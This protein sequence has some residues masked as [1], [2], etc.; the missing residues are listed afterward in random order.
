MKHFT[1]TTLA[2]P[3]PHTQCI[4]RNPEDK[5]WRI[6]DRPVVNVSEKMSYLYLFVI[7]SNL[8]LT[9]LLITLHLPPYQVS[10]ML[11]IQTSVIRETSS[12][13]SIKTYSAPTD[14]QSPH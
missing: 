4:Y 1:L 5:I 3:G 12:D 9:C 10:L 2:S 6:S 7:I 14:I 11:S 8:N 13:N